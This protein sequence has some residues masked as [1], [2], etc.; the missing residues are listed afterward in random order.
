MKRKCE[1]IQELKRMN[2]EGFQNP[3]LL[4]S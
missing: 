1:N 4:S 3:Q 2:C